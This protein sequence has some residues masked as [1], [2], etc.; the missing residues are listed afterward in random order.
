MGPIISMTA[1]I[2]GLLG[3]IWAMAQSICGTE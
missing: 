2:V 3:T 1:L